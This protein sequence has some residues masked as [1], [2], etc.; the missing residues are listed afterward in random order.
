MSTMTNYCYDASGVLT[1][2]HIAAEQRWRYPRGKL[3]VN[4]R[5]VHSDGSAVR[6]TWLRAGSSP[7][8]EQVEGEHPR[9]TLL[10]ASAHRTVMLSADEGIRKAAYAAHGHHAGAADQ[11]RTQLGFAGELREPGTG[12]YLLGAGHHRPYSPTL[13][14]FLAPDRASPF[15]RGG[16]NNLSY[17]AGDP[18]NRIDPSGHIWKWVVAAVGI[19]AGAIAIAASWGTASTAVGLVLTGGIKALTASGGSAIAGVG[20]GAAGV[21]VEVAAMGAAAAGDDKT[22]GILGWV[23]LGL[24]V[25]GVAPALAK[26][27]VKATTQLA[28]RLNRFSQRIGTITEQGLS[29]RGAVAAGRQMA[30]GGGRRAAATG[31]RR[32]T[33]FVP[34]G[35]PSGSGVSQNGSRLVGYHGTSRANADQILRTGSQRMFLTDRVESARHYARQVGG[36]DGVVLGMYADDV[37]TWTMATAPKINGK[38]YAEIDAYGRTMSARI[39]GADA[40]P[41]DDF[42]PFF[43]QRAMTHDDIL[44]AIRRDMGDAAFDAR[45]RN[46]DQH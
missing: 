18:I 36:H 11:A 25:A 43:Q 44:A 7:I 38:G 24:G 31:N 46:Y 40:A 1:G 4:E 32:M 39:A 5:Q 2:V 28:T 9:L 23:G 27:A 45:M 42:M 41:I 6:I 37:D 35:S 3:A 26:V 20:L 22:A 8:A 10:G 15:G 29:G 17:C 14:L 34:S 12:L 19:L 33:M 13:G 21:A 30:I 16:L